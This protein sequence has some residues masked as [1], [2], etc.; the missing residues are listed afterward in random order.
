MT[1]K[2]ARRGLKR[3]GDEMVDQYATDI[4]TNEAN[5]VIK[6]CKNQGSPMFLMV[7]H[8]AV[9]TGVP[10]PNIL[11]VQNKTLNDIKFNYIENKER[12]LFAGKKK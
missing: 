9:H 3:A 5:K 12:R 11:E 6:S 10:G 8:L 4:F 2:D 7:S 1:G